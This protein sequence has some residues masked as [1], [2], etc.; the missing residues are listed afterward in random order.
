MMKG[1]KEEF[2]WPTSVAGNLHRAHD[3]TTTL[4]ERSSNGK[5]APV[6]GNIFPQ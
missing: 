4:T 3:S 5:T 6:F 1:E 2:S